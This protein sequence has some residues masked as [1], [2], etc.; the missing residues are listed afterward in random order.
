MA[1]P[2]S[3]KNQDDRDSPSPIDATLSH[4][5]PKRAKRGKERARINLHRN[6]KPPEKSAPTA[7]HLWPHIGIS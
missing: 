5:I 1:Q 4:A 3:G 7:G 2:N 6:P